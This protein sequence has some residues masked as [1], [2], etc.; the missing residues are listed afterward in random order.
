MFVWNETK[1]AANIGKHGVDFESIHEFD[2]ATAFVW[3]DLRFPYGENRYCALGT[4]GRRVH[5]LTYAVRGEAI[6]L[7]SLRKANQRETRSYEEARRHH[8]AD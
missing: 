5:C 6:H 8:Y 3:P 2:F 4:I 1:R 7:I